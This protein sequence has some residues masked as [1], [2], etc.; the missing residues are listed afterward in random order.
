MTAIQALTEEE[1]HL[2]AIMDDASGIELAEFCFVDETSPDGCF[3]VRD[4]QWAWW[5]NE[6]TY[7]IDW[8]G[9]DLGKSTGVILR[10]LA[11]P[12]VYPGQEML[13]TA[14]E[15]NHLNPLTTRINDA[16][17][18]VRILRDMIPRTKHGGYGIKRQPHWEANFTNGSKI[19]SRLP[20]RDGRG[21]KGVHATVI[22]MDEAQDYVEEGWIEIIES[23]R[24]SME[25]ATWRAHGV[26]RGVRDRYYRYTS[27]T[28]PALPWYVHRYM[29]M[30]RGSWDRRERTAKV[31][32]YGG[33]EDNVD[34]RRNIYG[35]HGDVSNPVFVL[36]RLMAC[37]RMAE[38]PWAIEYNDEVY[39]VVKINE[40]LLKSS[41]A[42]IEAFIQ[43]PPSHF[44]DDYSSYWAGGDIGYTYDPSEFLI[45]GEVKK[46]GVL[47]LLQRVHLQRISAT[48]QAKVVMWLFN[49]Y[50]S[51]LR[52][53]SMDKTG[54]GLPLFQIISTQNP[55]I[56]DRLKGYHF[57]QKRIVEL[58]PSIEEEHIQKNVI[59]FATD[60]LRKLVD[61]GEIELPQDMELLTEFQGQEIHYVKDTPGS[62]GSFRK[63]FSGGT[64]HT[65][66][67]AKLMILARQ[68]DRI[69]KALANQRQPALDMFYV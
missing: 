35:D 58:S 1:C 53:F 45:F 57:S 59:E 52:A 48:D 4:Y 8:A 10:A 69:D 54:N 33:S 30:H 67:A 17:L 27:G 44:T 51:K 43:P 60:E 26:S 3:R 28:D 41:G 11:F 31:A 14:P 64:F 47:R 62:S 46:T 18:K 25:G 50:G 9:R 55:E 23:M 68:L 38:S 63:S 49:L 24:S 6:S 65:L 29:A 7:Q 16:M 19:I 12:L 32:I 37:V 22:E 39:D 56:L 21:V 34:Y 13:L 42:E 40:E 5:R 66:D 2:I 61:A 15:L 36:S 20:N